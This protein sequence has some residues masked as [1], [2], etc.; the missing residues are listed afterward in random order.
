M[1]YKFLLFILLFASSICNPQDYPR[2]N[3]WMHTEKF[4]EAEQIVMVKGLVPDE[5]ADEF[6]EICDIKRDDNYIIKNESELDENDEQKHLYF[7]GLTN[8]FKQINEFLPK[9]LQII[10]NGFTLG[11]YEFIDLLDVILLFSSEGNRYFCL[12]NSIEALNSTLS[13]VINM[14]Q[15]TIVQN[16]KPTHYGFLK[17]SGEFDYEDHVDIK[18]SRDQFLAKKSTEYFNFFYSPRMWSESEA[19]SI[20][21]IE[22]QN[23]RRA[24]D[25]LQLNQ[26]TKKIN[27]FIYMDK[28][29]KYLLSYTY[30]YGNVF[31]GAWEIHTLGTGAITH[32][33]I[34]LIYDYQCPNEFSFIAEGIVGYYYCMIDSN[35]LKENQ[36]FV[37]THY[38][39]VELKKYILD[40]DHFWGNSNY[41]YPFS[42]NFVKYLIE[43]YGFDE[44]KKYS[45]NSDLLES[46]LAVYGKSL[47]QIIKDWEA[48]IVQ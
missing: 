27:A 24:I 35:K 48:D 33:S 9:A 47:E 14:E 32:E 41:G 21:Y 36:K 3:L 38:R 39:N 46:C 37:K 22:N 16:Y 12:G 4:S 8:G 7:I 26:P 13:I 29:Q 42:A 1:K 2:L 40:D 30:G 34:H 23:I 31:H 18:K 43:Q 25:V 44:F 28:Y 11:P 45:N 20:C 10:E 19:D 5:L 15:Y 6:S 17:R